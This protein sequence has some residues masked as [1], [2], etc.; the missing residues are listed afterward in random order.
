MSTNVKSMLL[1]FQKRA[2][3]LDYAYKKNGEIENDW[4]AQHLEYEHSDSNYQSEGTVHVKS[5]PLVT[6]L[7]SKFKLTK[8]F[9]ILLNLRK[10]VLILKQIV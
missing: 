7:R 10:E 3:A 9:K 8:Q 5:F 2:Q 6:V 4:I 1:K